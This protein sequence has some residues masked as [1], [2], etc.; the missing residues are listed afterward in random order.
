MNKVILFALLAVCASAASWSVKSQNFATIAVAI[1]C[2]TTT[3]CIAPVG[4][5]GEGSFVWVSQDAGNT[6]NPANSPNE[7]MFLGAAAQGPSAVV[8]DEL[9]L[10]VASSQPYNFTNPADGSLIT[11]QNVEVSDDGTFYGAAG[12]DINGDNGAAISNDGG[13]SWKFFNASVL[14]T[15]ARYGAYPS[16]TTWYVSAGEWPNNNQASELTATRLTSRIH[17]EKVGNMMRPRWFEAS[18]V[19]SGDGWKAQ[20]VKTTDG[21][22]TWSSV[23]YDAGNF[24]FN[25]ISCGS[26]DHCCAVGEA[27]SSNSPG[28]RIYCTTDGGKTWERTLFQASSTLSIMAIEFLSDQEAWAAGGNMDPTNF[29]GYFWHTL[30]GGKTWTPQTVPGVYG[31]DLSFPANNVGFA[32]AFNVEDESSLLVFQ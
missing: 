26:V 21:G 1:A 12:Q 31:N 8:A 5:N 20:I 7:L 15:F 10:I 4:I 25:E 29:E 28:I 11:S 32:T 23:F 2:P 19:R 27:D 18:N 24:Y 13:E 17:L 14:E 22:K 9:S 6:W 3:T 16:L 30:D